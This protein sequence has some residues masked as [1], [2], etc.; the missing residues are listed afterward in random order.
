MKCTSSCAYAYTR[1]YS[2]LSFKGFILL[3]CRSVKGL[4]ILSSAFCECELTD[5]T[6]AVPFQ[7]NIT[8][9]QI[10]PEVII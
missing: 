2:C 10:W 3:K 9:R 6:E 4:V 7:S 1:T 8:E 5:L